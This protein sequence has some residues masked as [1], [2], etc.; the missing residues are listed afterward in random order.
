MSVVPD[1]AADYAEVFAHF[2]A[3]QVPE[4]SVYLWSPVFSCL[5][6]G[7]PRSSS[8]PGARQKAPR[9]WRR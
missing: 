2:G 8:A 4:H 7:R 3:E 6:G 9:P 5:I 1:P